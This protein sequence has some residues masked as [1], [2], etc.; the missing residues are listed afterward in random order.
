MRI[1]III[2]IIINIIMKQLTRRS[3]GCRGTLS[4]S[5]GAGVNGAKVIQF[6]LVPR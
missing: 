3:R 1:V 4:S 5:C 6:H 2:I